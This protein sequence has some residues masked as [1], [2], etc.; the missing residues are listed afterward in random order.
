MKDVI[1]KALRIASG[2]QTPNLEFPE[3]ED[4]GDFTSNVALVSGKP[5]KDIVEKLKKDKE[6][7]EIVAK[8]EIA[9]PGFINFFLS[10]ETLAGELEKVL[11]EGNNYGSS[12]LGEGKTVVVDYSS[13][14]IAKRFGIG[15]LRS[16]VIGQALYNLYQALGYK[17]IGDNH[18]GDWGTQFGVLLAQIEDSGLK[19]QDL[20]LDKLEELYVDFHKK[21]EADPKLWDGARAWFKKLEEG[22]SA[23]KEIWK[24]LVE[25][26]VTEFN[27]IYKLLG[28]KIDYAYGESF[29]EDYMPKVINLLREKGLVKKSQGAEIVEFKDLPPA[30]LVKSDGATTYFTRDLATI[31]FRVGSWNPEIIIYEV[32]MEQTLHFRQIFAAAKLLGWAKDRELVHIGHGLIRFEHGKMSTRRGDTVKL[33]DVLSEATS[34]AGK[35]IEASETGRGL[36]DKEKEEVAEAVGIGAIKYFDLSHHPATD[37]IFDWEKLFLLEGNSAPYLQYTAVRA[38]SVLKKAKNADLDF[39]GKEL[40]LNKEEAR[41]I[42]GLI[43]FPEVII[44]AAKNYSPNLLTNYLFGLAQKFNNFYNQHRI[45]GGENENFRLALTKAVGEVLTHGLGILGIDTPERM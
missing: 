36:S 23:A 24:N 27:R 5:A 3:N 43:R 32:G 15:H 1:L 4:F 25:I 39:D 6:L 42:S 44:A 35:I 41:V 17:V 28:V 7:A 16:T 31:L 19:T 8:I 2:E 10:E 29:Y 30:M 12:N 22:D 34:R 45:I 13:P 9:G 38:D 21:A 14:N 11:R 20:T 33:E 40:K 26:S 18:L 37:I